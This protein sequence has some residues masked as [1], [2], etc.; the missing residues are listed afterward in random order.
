M[1]TAHEVIEKILV[2]RRKEAQDDAVAVL[3]RFTM[4]D[5]LA[6][7][8]NYPMDD[9]RT[10]LEAVAQHPRLAQAVLEDLVSEG[11]AIASPNLQCLLS[12]VALPVLRG[13]KDRWEESSR[14]QVDVLDDLRRAVADLAD[15]KARAAE[16]LRERGTLRD[17]LATETQA[18]EPTIQELERLEAEIRQYEGRLE[19]LTQDVSVLET[20]L[21]NLTVRQT[22]LAD[23]KTHLE[24]RVNELQVEVRD[25]ARLV[26][27]QLLDEQTQLE[28][29][30]KQ[31]RDPGDRLVALPNID[32]EQWRELHEERAQLRR[33]LLE[34]E[35]RSRIDALVRRWYEIQP[36]T[37]N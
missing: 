12:D 36:P 25:L 4:A 22:E 14:Q 10:F 37:K 26:E 21:A 19:I 8:H 29:R 16:R 32:Q 6:E 34:G 27:K 17:R 15:E 30:L 24:S 23:Q 7:L 1:T 33:L 31:L 20:K 35:L 3:I 11:E 13:A 2:S 18:R 28:E 9:W 5:V